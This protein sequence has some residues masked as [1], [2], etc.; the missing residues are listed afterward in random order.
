MF[1]SIVLI[2]HQHGI[3][4]LKDEGHTPVAIHSHGPMPGRKQMQFPSRHVHVIGGLG[5]NVRPRMLLQ[6]AQG[7]CQRNQGTRGLPSKLLRTNSSLTLQLCS[8]AE[9]LAGAPQSGQAGCAHRA[10]PCSLRACRSSWSPRS[11][12]DPRRTL[13]ALHATRK[14]GCGRAVSLQSQSHVRRRHTGAPRLGRIRHE[15][16]GYA[17]TYNLLLLRKGCQHRVGAAVVVARRRTT[18]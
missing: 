13:G 3:I 4:P 5:K 7:K 15:T 8:K 17:V 18:R 2:I 6:R 16:R 10:R 1:L 12:G 11:N 9:G 14:A